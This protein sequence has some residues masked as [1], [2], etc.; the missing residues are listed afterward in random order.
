MMDLR[1]DLA[2]ERHSRLAAEAHAARLAAD[3]RRQ[4]R[5]RRIGRGFRASGSRTTKVR[6]A[7]H[8]A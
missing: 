5:N 4:R 1:Y 8:A 6:L 2:A 7:N 3:A